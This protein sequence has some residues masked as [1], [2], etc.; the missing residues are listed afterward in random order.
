MWKTQIGKHKDWL[1]NNRG[2]KVTL[3][4]TIWSRWL[5]AYCPGSSELDG[6]VAVR[7][8]TDEGWSGR[9]VLCPSRT[10]CV[11]TRPNSSEITRILALEKCPREKS[12]I[13]SNKE[14]RSS[15][16]S[17]VHAVRAKLTKI[18]KFWSSSDSSCSKLIL[19]RPSILACRVG[20]GIAPAVRSVQSSG[21]GFGLGSI[22][23][24]HGSSR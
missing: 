13:G 10:S 7:S 8:R 17:L 4:F 2:V 21:R 3:R 14:A 9:P 15:V 1:E 19:A 22:P 11:P 23:N 24:V 5:F 18:E 6:S 12:I 20:R 16:R